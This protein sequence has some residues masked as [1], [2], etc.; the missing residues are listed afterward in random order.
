MEIFEKILK[1]FFWVPLI[2]GTI[3]YYLAGEKGFWH[4]LYA[5][6]ACYFVN[7]VNDMDN[8]LIITSKILAVVVTTGV[9][10]SIL[11]SVFTAIMRFFKRFSADATVVYGDSEY[12]KNLAEKLRHGYHIDDATEFEKV[13]DHILMYE[14]DTDALRFLEQNKENIKDK[15][16]YLILDKADTFLLSDTA[17]TGIHYQSVSEICARRFWREYSLYNHVVTENKPAKIAFIGMG[18]IG[19][20]LFRYGYLNNVYTTTQHIE[21]H[22]YGADIA[23]KGE[24]NRLEMVNDDKIICHE[25]DYFESP[26]VSKM[27]YIIVTPLSTNK[28]F[29]LSCDAEDMTMIL[30][31]LLRIASDA[32]IFLYEE[33]SLKYED[34]YA[35]DR[36]VTFGDVSKFLTEDNIK[37]EPLDRAAKLFNYDYELRASGTHA[38]DDYME[39][40]EECWQ[41]LNGFFRGSNV[42]RADHHFIEMRREEE[43]A[44]DHEIWSVEHTRWCRYYYINGWSYDTKRDNAKKKHPLL[45]PYEE[46]ELAEQQKDG[47]YDQRIKEEIEGICK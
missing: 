13:R 28:I 30:S 33:G 18:P 1:R 6:I 40:A 46:L 21:Y 14:H 16:V 4:C 44:N 5:S 36:I 17:G 2:M 23:T 26:D 7:P 31:R 42:A 3:G 32:R 19:Y 45:V 47:I 8:P 11:G 24:I 38:T 22:I 29:N 27:D 43:G 10:L 12:G 9:V 35:S 25:E 39:K 37:N 34:I 15:N 20:A 41:K